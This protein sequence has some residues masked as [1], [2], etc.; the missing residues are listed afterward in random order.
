MPVYEINKFEKRNNLSINV[1]YFNTKD[2]QDKKVS[3]L[4]ISKE[5]TTTMPINLL[6]LDNGIKYHYTYIKKFSNLFYK[7]VRTEKICPYCMQSFWKKYEKDKYD[8]YENHVRFCKTYRPM[9]TKIPKG[10]KK[11]I[12]FNKI[13]AM[14]KHPVVM[15][16]DFEA[17]N[18][19][20]KDEELNT[21]K[22]KKCKKQEIS[23]YSF[24]IVSPYF[25]NRIFTYRGENAVKHFL[26]TII[27]E[28]K[29]IEKFFYK[30]QKPINQL[31][32]QELY[33]YTNAS[34]CYICNDV[35]VSESY[36]NIQITQLIK[37][38][39]EVDLPTNRIP[40]LANVKRKIR[41]VKVR[42]K[43]N[44]N[45]EKC[46]LFQESQKNLLH[47]LEEIEDYLKA[48]NVEWKNTDLLPSDERSK[49][50]KDLE[51]M[52][53][54]KKGLKV[55]D[56]C[57]W[58][59]KFRGAAHALCNL[60]MRKFRKIP[61]F[62][63]NFA[64]YDSHLL[65]RGLDANLINKSPKIIPKS[66]EKFI[67]LSLEKIEFK[68]SLQ[69]LNG[70]LERLVLNL[71]AKDINI[72]EQFPITYNHFRKKWKHLDVDAFE[73]LTEKLIYPYSYFESFST[74]NEEQLPKITDFYNDLTNTVINNDDYEKVKK[75]WNIFELKNLGDLHDLYVQT[76]VLL[77]ADC[78]EQFRKFALNNY[79]LDPAH[80]LSAPSLSWES[81]LLLTD[82]KLEI[83]QDIEM[84]LF[85]DRYQ[86]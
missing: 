19:P 24:I 13:E 6:V 56:H 11:W 61:C 84:H 53:L 14:E 42:L 29:K 66:L 64:G 83:P 10:E 40:S 2:S 69:F 22:T 75:L 35:F 1:Y 46:Q 85:I 15:Y 79:K 12:K 70:S 36:D 28:Q 18:V 4:Y 73:M 62:F 82:V 44:R 59:G 21:K 49:T 25:E 77:L 41:Q 30:N 51:I 8:N 48:Q 78:F 80:F 34:H 67:Y 32:V 33:D 76:D 3:P 58:T 23:G 37:L 5:R 43:S 9:E 54:L 72:T 47:K 57:H 60:Q 50:E 26:E 45:G 20:V 74:F 17:L 81:A 39:Q 71:K 68:D 86:F 27:K 7:K 63:H 55:K 52:R 31:S 38:L 16:A 65:V